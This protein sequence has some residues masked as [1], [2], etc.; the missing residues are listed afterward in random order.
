MSYLCLG[1]I[2]ATERPPSSCTETYLADLMDLL[3]QTA[4]LARE[5]QVK[6][7]VWAGDVFHVKAASRN[8]HRLVQLFQQLIPEY[9]C[10]VYVVPGNHDLAYDRLD[11]LA[12]TQPLGVL[13]RSGQLRMLNGWCRDGYPLYGVPWQQ[14]WTDDAVRDALA[15]W[16]EQVFEAGTGTSHPLVVT[17]APLYPPGLELE[18][19]NYPAQKWAEAMGGTGACYYGHVHER[20]GIWR[21]AA[22]WETETTVENGVVTFCNPGAISRGSLHEHNLS[23]VPACV[24]WDEEDGSFEEIPLDAK[25]PSQVFRLT[26][27]Q[28]VTDMRGRLDEFLESVGRSELEIM[29]TESVAAHLRGLALSELD[30]ALALDLLA[31]AAK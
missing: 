26:E 8:S 16:R 15:G 18:F 23:R 13:I 5:R 1:D 27:A 4:R 25:H 28:E 19:E 6:A 20:H 24:I 12:E 9:G 31:E 14:K 29:T 11:S 17:H 10:P 3:R 7:V 30:L 21:A 2:H 22:S